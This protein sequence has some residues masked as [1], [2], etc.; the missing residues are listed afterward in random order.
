M[1]KGLDIKPRSI[2]LSHPINDY[3]AFQTVEE[4]NGTYILQN[5]D[6]QQFH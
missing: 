5:W 1:N 3:V 2:F 6:G 4:L